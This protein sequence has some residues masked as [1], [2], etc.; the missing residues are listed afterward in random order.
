MEQQHEELPRQ[1][2]AQQQHDALMKLP[3]LKEGFKEK[4]DALLQKKANE[5]H[6][7]T[8][9]SSEQATLRQ[10]G[11]DAIASARKAFKKE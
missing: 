9:T 5:S 10:F 3:K 4:L 1:M 2:D 11:K 6:S 7:E 8:L